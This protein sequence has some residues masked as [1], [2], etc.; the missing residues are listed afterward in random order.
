MPVETLQRP[1]GRPRKFAR[2][3]VLSVQMPDDLMDALDVIAERTKRDR[4]SHVRD[5]IEV[6]LDRFFL[7]SAVD[8]TT[9]KVG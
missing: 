7:P 3:R 5:A 2:R 1:P 4:S 6:Y 9:R 8:E